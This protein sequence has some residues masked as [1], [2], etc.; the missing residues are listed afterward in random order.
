[1]LDW[2]NNKNLIASWNNH[3]QQP[4]RVWIQSAI[5]C[6]CFCGG[7]DR[8]SEMSQRSRGGALC[9]STWGENRQIEHSVHQSVSSLTSMSNL[10]HLN[11]ISMRRA[12]FYNEVMLTLTGAQPLCCVVVERHDGHKKHTP[13]ADTEN[14]LIRLDSFK[15]DCHNLNEIKWDKIRSVLL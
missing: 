10:Q 6:G 12:V 14:H 8:T 4:E 13:H 1:M 5:V 3:Q 7:A 15:L 11:T 9:P 2:K